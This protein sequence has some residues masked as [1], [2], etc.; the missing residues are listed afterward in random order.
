M[1]D[2]PA[3][4]A[5]TMRE[6]RDALGH[7]RPAVPAV[8]PTAPPAAAC[9]CAVGVASAQ[10]SPRGCDPAEPDEV[11][12]VV[13]DDSDDP[14]CIED[15]PGCETAPPATDL[16]DRIAS[17]PG[18]ETSPNPCRCPCYGCLHH[19]SAHDPSEVLPVPADRVTVMQEAVRRARY[20]AAIRDTDGWVLDGGQ[21][22][23]DAVMAVADAEQTAL[24]AEADALSAELTRR[25]PLLGEH[26]NEI[27]RLR[28]EVGRLRADRAAVLREAADAIE[29]KAQTRY[30]RS[31]SDNSIF[32]LKGARAVV[33]ELRR[34]AD[35]AQQP[36]TE[37]HEHVPVTAL[38]G[39]DRPALDEHG[40]TWTHCGICG[41]RPAP[42]EEPTR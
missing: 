22:M 16:R 10:C 37:A 25:A 36:E 5:M 9:P 19:C 39:D 21:H 30:D 35:E 27:I 28:A 31:H 24:R 15:C 26:A 20:A 23:V 8:A 13:G 33:A 12:H 40:H 34:L 32:E 3:R 29:A 17:C 42:T 2:Q 6:M 11:A 14:E 4:P 7:T 18:Y 1:T 41:Q 38:D